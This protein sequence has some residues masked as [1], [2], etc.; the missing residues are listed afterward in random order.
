MYYVL[1]NYVLIKQYKCAFRISQ[2]YSG[3]LTVAFKR[4]EHTEIRAN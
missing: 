4:T 2:P 1:S 3:N